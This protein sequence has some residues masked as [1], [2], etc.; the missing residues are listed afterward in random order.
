MT[1][2]IITDLIT[3]IVAARADGHGVLTIDAVRARLT[4]AKLYVLRIDDEDFAG[5]DD[6]HAWGTAQT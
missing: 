4:E 1:D 2:D 5:H 6:P 3:A